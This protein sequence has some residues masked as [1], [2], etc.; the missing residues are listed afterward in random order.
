MLSQASPSFH[1][2]NQW[3]ALHPAAPHL[4]LAAQYDVF[5]T[6][7]GKNRFASGWVLLHGFQNHPCCRYCFDFSGPWSESPRQ[8]LTSRPASM[9]ECE[10]SVP[11]RRAFLMS[12]PLPP[13]PDVE[14]AK[15]MS[16][17]SILRK[18]PL[19]SSLYFPRSVVAGTTRSEELAGPVGAKR[20]SNPWPP[21]RI[22]LHAELHPPSG[23]RD[24]DSCSESTATAAAPR[25]PMSRILDQTNLAHRSTR[26][27]PNPLFA[28][29]A[30]IAVRKSCPKREAH[31]FLLGIRGAA[32]R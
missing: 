16:G 31:I 24:P 28:R 10:K 22:P 20:R 25:P 19:K 7:I 11:A 9:P 14:P 15:H 8:P 3:L 4:P 6:R 17:H 29:P 12:M 13:I 21:V 26:R 2:S 5:L 32:R 23:M 27:I 18:A 1:Q 30:R